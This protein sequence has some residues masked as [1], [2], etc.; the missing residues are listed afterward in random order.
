MCACPFDLPLLLP[1]D[2]VFALAFPCSLEVFLKLSWIYLGI[3]MAFAIFAGARNSE[4]S[5]AKKARALYHHSKRQ[6]FFA[7]LQDLQVQTKP[8]TKHH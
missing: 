2:A 1:S 3:L 4:L 8:V 5:F 7:M 6:A